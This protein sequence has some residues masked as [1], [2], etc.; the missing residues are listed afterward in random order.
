MPGFSAALPDSTVPLMNSDNYPLPAMT[1]ADTGDTPIIL[2]VLDFD[3]ND[4]FDFII[5][6]SNSITINPT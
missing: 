1:D 5:F 4:R 3:T 6:T 2:D